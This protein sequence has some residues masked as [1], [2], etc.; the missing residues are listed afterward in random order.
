MSESSFEAT[1]D[2]GRVTAD[3]A[4]AVQSLERSAAGGGVV[5][6]E[7]RYFGRGSDVDDFVPTKDETFLWLQC[8]RPREEDH[9]APPADLALIRWLGNSYYR[10]LEQSDLK[11]GHMRE[12][13]IRCGLTVGKW[14][15]K[16]TKED[17]DA[18]WRTLALGVRD[19]SL[20]GADGVK[21]ATQRNASTNV[22]QGCCYTLCVY[23]E[24]GLTD[25]G[26]VMDLRRTLHHL[27]IDEKSIRPLYWKPD[28]YT[29]LPLTKTTYLWLDGADTEFWCEHWNGTVIF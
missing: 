29:Y 17:V 10:G 13:A 24:G 1:G 14:M 19:G 9:R 20:R 5:R 22:A 27:R 25:P 8:D 26:A 21:C 6:E 16:T 4:R 7:R 12:Q 2:S 3:M 15:I 28:F 11:H 18:L 23:T